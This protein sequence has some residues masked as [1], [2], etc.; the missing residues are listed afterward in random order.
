[1]DRTTNDTR[2][3]MTGRE[4]ILGFALVGAVV[5]SAAAY[6]G[7][8]ASP[9]ILGLLLISA[10]YR[11]RL[12]TLA[13]SLVGMGLGTLLVLWIGSRCPPATTCTADFPIQVYVATAAAALALGTL[14]AVVVRMREP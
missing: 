8:L 2:H 1:M 12:A 5:G 6:F 4:A 10:V 3:P 13:G 9:A 14:L 11:P 7:Y